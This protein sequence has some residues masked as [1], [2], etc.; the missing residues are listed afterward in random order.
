MTAD[1]VGGVWTYALELARGLAGQRIEVMLAV[2]GPAPD[3][4][5]R[6][7]A[8]RGLR[9]HR[10]RAGARVAGPGRRP[11]RRSLP[12][13]PGPGERVPPRS[14]PHQRL[15]RGRCRLSGPGDAGRPLLRR[16][17]VAGVPWRRAAARLERLC[18]RR[19]RRAGCGRRRRRAHPRVPRGA[20]GSMGDCQPARHPQRPRACAPIATPKRRSILAAGRLWDEAKN[21]AALAAVAPGLPWPVQVAGEGACRWSASPWSPDPPRAAPPHGRSRDLRRPGALRAVR[22]GG[23][24]GRGVRLRPGA[25]RHP[26]PGRAL[27]RGGEVRAAGRPGRRC[28]ARCCDLI[29]D[30][31]RWDALQAAA[32]RAA[33]GFS[34]GPHGRRLSRPLR[35]AA[36]RPRRGGRAA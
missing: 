10:H 19:A 13:P 16:D 36:G 25:G 18:S 32:R 14:R 5:Q 34:A 21:I 31:R 3:E 7:E 4:E 12:E 30:P 6:E 2:L 27:G 15:P 1:A 24:G 22:P 26:E 23:P 29:D 8:R 9:C 11:G 20:F 33:R 35:R 28:A 17:L